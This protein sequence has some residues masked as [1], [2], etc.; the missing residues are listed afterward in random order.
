MEQLKNRQSRVWVSIL[1]PD[2]PKHEKALYQ[3]EI[4]YRSIMMYHNEIKDPDTNDIIEKKHCHCILRFESGKWI[5]TILKDLNLDESDLHLF[6]TLRD[7]HYKSVDDYIVYMTH[8]NE[9]DKE[10]YSPL[11]FIGSDRN[12]AISVCS[13]INKSSFQLFQECYQLLSDLIET[14]PETHLWT[15]KQFYDYCDERGY[16]IA[17][18]K[19]WS[20]FKD[21]IREWITYY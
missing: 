8:I 2:N 5:S 18:Y 1:Y 13:Q 12:Y 7:I 14:M 17:F 21:I 11:E 10:V 4:T 16:A 3:I 6:R 20:K 15:F 9:S 19:N